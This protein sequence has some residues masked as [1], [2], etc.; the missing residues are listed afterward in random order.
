MA[1][2]MTFQIRKATIQDIPEVFSFELAYI[3]EIEPGVEE[4]W[5][6]SIQTL[7]RQWIANLPRMFIAQLDGEPIGHC[8]WQMEGRT[9]LLA[10]IYIA[11]TWRRKGYGM[12]LLAGY[13]RDAVENG[14]SHLQIG[15]HESNPA[16]ALYQRAGYQWTH[17][18]NSY[19]YYEKEQ[20]LRDPKVIV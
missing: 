16:S 19:D 7:L 13:E 6:H 18:H 11:P 10:S 15:V 12:L 2:N 9:A 1:R 14:F 20:L 8:F 5:K 17:K 4:N 3:Q